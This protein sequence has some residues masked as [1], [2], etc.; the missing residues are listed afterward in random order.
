MAL[1]KGLFVAHGFY[2][3]HVHGGHGLSRPT[4]VHGV[5]NGSGE[6]RSDTFF[7]ASLKRFKILFLCLSSSPVERN[8]K[9]RFYS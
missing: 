1:G 4:C 9:G 6:N 8:E 2:V 3:P 7:L 5:Q